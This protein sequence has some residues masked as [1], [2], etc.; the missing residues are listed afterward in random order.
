MKTKRNKGLFILA[1]SAFIVTNSFG[2]EIPLV[3]D[4][5][6]TGA[7]FTEPILPALSE[8]PVIEPLTDPFEWSD[9][10]GRSTDF[11]DWSHRR[12]EIGAELENYEIGEKPVRPDTITASYANK[13]LTVNVTKN[14]QTLTLTSQI[15][16]PSGD[17]PFPAVIGINSGTGSLPES[18][19][20][21]RN[22]ATITFN[23][24]QVVTYGS[25]F[26]TDPY[27]K[28]YPDL[29]YAGQY[30]A[31][32]WGISRIIDG[33]EL[34]KDVLPVDLKHL[35]VTGCS[36]AGKLALFA[37]A[38][39]E[40]IALTIAEESGGG[41]A[42]AWRVS[43]TL[44]GVESLGNT[45]F[46]WFKSDMSQFAGKNVSKLPEDHHE[47]MAMV[48][49][50]A[51]LVLGNPSYVW[52]AD[53]SGYVSCRA[54]HEVWKTFGIADRFGFSI[55]GDHMHCSLPTNQYPEV[56]AFVEKF[57]LGDST[58]NT[59][60]TIHPYDNVDYSRWTDWWATGNPVFAKRDRFGNE[61]IW[62]EAECATVGKDWKIMNYPIASNSSLISL[63]SGLDSTKVA[64]TDSASSI[65]FPFTVTKDTVY[66][67]FARILCSAAKGDSYWVKMDDSLFVRCDGLV[68]SGLQWK[69]L[70]SSKL[71]A[72]AHTLTIAY[73]AV[74][75][76]L[77]KLCISN[78][79]YLPSL[80]GESAVN[81]CV[82]DITPTGVNSLP[83]I[84][85]YSLGNYP[86]P[87]ND[88]TTITFEIPVDTY[89]SLKVFNVK[90]VEISELAGMKYLKGKHSIDFKM[91]DLPTGIY[92]YT[93]KTDSYSLSQKMV[94]GSK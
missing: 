57:L 21:N 83:V 30:S 69:Q 94:I 90:G 16:L 15:S 70:I 14:G 17:G 68:T 41:G 63:K 81:L 73:N 72:G 62:L 78:S 56:E 18:I 22:I 26:K 27:Y 29:Y 38:F 10:S 52:L 77:D 86:N 23:H 1:I 42:A 36:Y 66:Y 25:R 74:G 89:V 85:G 34:V 5:E 2:Q 91:K 4:V 12:A 80:G 47:L 32:S 87:V 65:Y 88:Y 54:A 71:T 7:G 37:G 79:K 51:L 6:N 43:E 9:R 46:T 93:L 39:D 31:W 76:K 33:L 61:S 8:L 50:R 84:E 28:L 45:N 44:T 13:T 75:A 59:N 60:V 64:P 35:A 3:Y 67:V 92:M 48:A 58:A 19:F 40:R 82:P 55:V 11:N 20:T 49:P 24:N 53:E